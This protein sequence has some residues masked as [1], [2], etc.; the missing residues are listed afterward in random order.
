M[1]E[2]I[3]AKLYAE[4]MHHQERQKALKAKSLAH[5]LEE[6]LQEAEE[7]AEGIKSQGSE[8][9]RELMRALQTVRSVFPFTCHYALSYSFRMHTLLQ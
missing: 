6:L 4:E 7:R 3:A 9:I 2:L 1:I 5:H 8:R